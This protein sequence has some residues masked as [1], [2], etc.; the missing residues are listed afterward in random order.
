MYNISSK[1]ILKMNEL[2]LSRF[3]SECEKKYE[4]RLLPIIDALDEDDVNIAVLAGPSCSGKTTSTNILSKELEKSG[5]NVTLISTDDFFKDRGTV[6]PDETGAPN[7]D[8]FNY[9]DSDYL[10]SVLNDISKGKAV[11]LPQYDFLTGCR[12]KDYIDYSPKAK[13]LLIIEGIHGLND[14]IVNS[15]NKASFIGIYICVKD[16]YIIDKKIVFTQR[17][18]RFLRRICRDF[19]YRGASPET[20]FYLWK[21]VIWG[22]DRFITPFIK[23][24]N[25]FISSNFEY[26]PF[27]IKQEALELLRSIK[28][29]STYHD[30]ASVL[31]N[32]LESIPEINP[33][34][35]PE[36]SLLNEFID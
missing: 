29:D 16:E 34:L 4:D 22:E 2:Q 30:S 18:I 9:V 11:K 3:I 7:Y 14:L 19:K 31:I 5:R 32:K 36:T 15:L 33:T 26:E 24:A 27:I 25:M 20:T 8:N 28:E 13:D 10:F 6:P 23:N 1:K 35:L 17:D 21:N 12:K